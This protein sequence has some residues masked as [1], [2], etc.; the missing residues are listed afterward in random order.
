M[1]RFPVL[2]RVAVTNENLLADSIRNDGVHLR[3][4][5]ILEEILYERIVGLVR[6]LSNKYFMS[7]SNELDDLV[8]DCLARVW[9]SRSQFDRNKASLSTWVWTVCCSVLNSDF[10]KSQ[11]YKNVFKFISQPQ[12]GDESQDV[13]EVFYST[14]SGS[15]SEGE[16][17]ISDVVGMRMA[18]EHLYEQHSD[19]EKRRQM[20]DALF[21]VEED[22]VF[23]TSTHRAAFRMVMPLDAVSNDIPDD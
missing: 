20:L 2:C 19:N 9:G 1:E 11:R 23:V 13:A 15:S 18:I 7:S 5:P 6:N 4:N 12:S 21:C 8:Q 14:T 22:G 16:M 10:R 17:G 3:E